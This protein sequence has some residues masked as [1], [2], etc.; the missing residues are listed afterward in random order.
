MRAPVHRFVFAF[1]VFLATARSAS[2]EVFV[3]AN[4]DR[5]TGEIVEQDATHITVQTTLMGKVRIPRSALQSPPPDP[6]PAAEPPPAVAATPPASTHPPAAESTPGRRNHLPRRAYA[7]WN[8]FWEDNVF[9]RTLS[10]YYPLMDWDNRINLG[11]SLQNAKKDTFNLDTRFH[12]ETRQGK[13]QA[14]FD[15]RYQ[16]SENT[17]LET[18]TVDG[19]ATT[20]RVR[21][22]TKD[23][24]RG[25]ARYRF[26]YVKSFFLQSDTRYSRDLVKKI[27]HE[28]DELFGI[29]YRWLDRDGIRSTITP[30]IG[31]GYRDIAPDNPLWQWLVSLQQ[32]FEF[33]LTDRV[34]VTQE[35]VLTYSPSEL[36][37]YTYH[38]QAGLENQLNRRLNL[39]LGYD[40]T[41]DERVQDADDRLTHGFSMSFGAKF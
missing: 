22:K 11:I 36:G 37:D 1:L 28:G 29:G 8:S 12:T 39:N 15:L 6:A 41:Y 14:L 33:R 3:L 9:F 10:R 5:L 32:D 40:L 4:G 13:H 7:A 18:N 23:L 24:L 20:T 26:D 17:A 27:F 25:N 2:A 16:F 30:S 34:K 35:S 31:V 38:F 21:S 19:V